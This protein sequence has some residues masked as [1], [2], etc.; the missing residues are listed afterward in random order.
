MTTTLEHLAFRIAKLN[1]G[2]EKAAAKSGKRRIPGDGDGD[3][4]PYEGRKPGAGTGAVGTKAKASLKRAGFNEFKSEGVFQ[5]ILTG[6]GAENSGFEV[7]NGLTRAGWS[8][9]SASYDAGKGINR[10]TMQH[11]DGSK[12]AMTIKNRAVKQL[13]GRS[14]PTSTIRVRASNE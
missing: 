7:K 13:G 3:G 11:S 9:R 10:Y 14:V 6:H 1:V 5:R 12:I 8:V 4:I 2:M